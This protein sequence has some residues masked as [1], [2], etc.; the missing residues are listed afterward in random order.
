MILFTFDTSIETMFIL[1][2]ADLLPAGI[3]LHPG[4]DSKRGTGIK[5][6][7]DKEAANTP[8][9][10]QHGERRDEQEGRHKG[11]KSEANPEE[12]KDDGGAESRCDTAYGEGD[13]QEEWEGREQGLGDQEGE[14]N[15]SRRGECRN[16]IVRPSTGRRGH[17]PV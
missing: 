12:R 4:I 3:D 1:Q 11:E 9:P 8:G 2:D 16:V 7:R 17:E 14:E 13:E 6:P 5:P 15:G 10:Q